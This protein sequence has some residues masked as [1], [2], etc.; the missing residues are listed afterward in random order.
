MIQI[1]SNCLGDEELAAVKRVFDSKWLGMGAEC[2]AFE[3]ELAAHFAV[4]ETLLFN[5]CSAAIYTAVR[6]LGIGKGDEVIISTANFVA[7]PNA[8][9]D[10][11][12]KPVFA[13]IHPAFHSILPG[14]IDRLKTR[15][16][17]AVFFL[18][19]GGHPAPFDE[20]RAAAGGKLLLLEDSA[21]AVS[22]RYKG[23]SCGA[24]GDAGVFSF[25]AM[26]TLVMGDGGALL[27]KDP[28]IFKHAQA[29][30]YL[31][32][33]STTTSGLA[34]SQ[35][36]RDR[37]WEYDLDVTSGRY[38]SNDILAA[39]GRIQLRKLPSFIERR[40]Q[41]WG[42]YQEK[43]AGISGLVTPPEPLPQTTS[44][45]YLYWIKVPKKRDGLARF[46]KERGIYTTFRY[47]PLHKV[48][49]YRDHS[50][51]PNAEEMNE[52]LLNLPLHQN[53]SDS[54]VNRVTESVR[55]FFR[56]P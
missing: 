47:F 25:D 10:A 37:W 48:P 55:E 19:Y 45:Y 3:K 13:D 4:K 53:L 15:K 42:Y 31:G 51:L 9:L 49:Y 23:V 22:S 40:K 33:S 46:L 20:I 52:T 56:R 36:G 6:A 7:V 32:Y 1:F 2:K 29:L 8:V 35:S 5:C 50:R 30:R 38:I 12:A 54:D 43:L 39:I 11:G 41:V 18:H 34:A 16:T 44:S 26:K 14:E 21:N 24:L 27:M 17:R 28:E